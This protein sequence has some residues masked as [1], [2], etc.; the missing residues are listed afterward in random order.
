MDNDVDA[1]FDFSSNSNFKRTVV[2]GGYTSGRVVTD[3]KMFA[4]K[5]NRK[6]E[7]TEY[8]SKYQQAEQ[9]QLIKVL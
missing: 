9:E 5:V 1:F 3:P 8:V 6:E 4:E 7:G 2:S